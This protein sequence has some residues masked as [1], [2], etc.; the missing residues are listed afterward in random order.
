MP[1]GFKAFAG[2]NITINLG[3]STFIGKQISNLNCTWYNGTVQIANNISGLY[4]KLVITTT[5][6][7]Q[8]NLCGN[9]TTA[10]VVVTV[11]TGAGIKELEQLKNITVTPNPNIGKI[12]LFR[13]KI[14]SNVQIK[15]L[16]L[17]GQIILTDEFAGA[18]KD[19]DLNFENGLYILE[20]VDMKTMQKII[21]KIIIQK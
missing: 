7:V 3:D 8:Q 19:L 17:T 16:N 18:K 21:K 20:L 2:N 6:V 14:L 11:N 5:Y 12:T 10:S 15:L 4:V 9:T 13:D 1:G